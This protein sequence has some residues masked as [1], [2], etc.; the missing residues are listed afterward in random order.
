M[1]APIISIITVCYNAAGVIRPTLLSVSEQTYP[2]IEYIIIDGASTD[3]TL[4]IA[5]ALAPEAVIH[6]A[7]DDGIY[8]A[9][10]RGLSRA[11][12]HY[13]WFLNAGDALPAPDTVARVAQ[14]SASAPRGA[15]IVYGD[16]LIVDSARRILGPRRHRPPKA[17]SWQSFRHGMTVCHQSFIARRRICPM[18]DTRYRF[19]ADVD[20][21]IRTMK[22]AHTYAFIDAPLSLY[23]S[24]GAT[25][26]NHRRSLMERF[27]VMR[28]H[29]G[30]RATIAAHLG[31]ALRALKRRLLPRASKP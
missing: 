9:M 30:L 8:D 6:S 1:T 17:L 13:V 11:T 26:T 28:R 16:C 21:C 25:T 15:D 19:S 7:P 20:W 24:E 22:A 5:R 29:Y 18:Y 14:A 23:L 2:H 10:N 27:A 4:Q 3:E 12:G 31:F